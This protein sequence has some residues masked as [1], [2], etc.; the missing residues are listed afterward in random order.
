M[1][2]RMGAEGT[3]NVSTPL[4]LHPSRLTSLVTAAVPAGAAHVPEGA[5]E[6]GL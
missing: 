4:T 1:S 3:A 6:I 5:G 2:R